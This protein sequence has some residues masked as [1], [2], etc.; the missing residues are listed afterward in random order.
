MPF[1]SPPEDE[2]ILLSIVTVILRL[3]AASAT[4]DNAPLI[5]GC[6]GADAPDMLLEPQAG[7][8]WE[9]YIGK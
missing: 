8:P 2:C 4:V 6:D 1:S 7:S 3:T 9:A 5:D